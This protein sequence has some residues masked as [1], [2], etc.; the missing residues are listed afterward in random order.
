MEIT[1]DIDYVITYPIDLASEELID[2]DSVY[3]EQAVNRELSK[4]N[5]RVFGPVTFGYMY[6]MVKLTGLRAD[7]TR[8]LRDWYS[9]DIDSPSEVEA[10]IP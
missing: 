6:P 3:I 5:V 4:Y 2:R 9:V 7:V 1:P 10:F 8:A